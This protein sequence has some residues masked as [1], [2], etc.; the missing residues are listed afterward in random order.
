MKTQIIALIISFLNITPL[1]SQEYNVPFPE[2][3]NFEPLWVY[4]PSFSEQNRDDRDTVKDNRLYY[5]GNVKYNSQIFFLYTSLHFFGDEI[6]EFSADGFSLTSM[7]YHSGEV[8][9]KDIYNHPHG[10]DDYIVTYWNDN[11][12]FEKDTLTLIGNRKYDEIGLNDF[13]MAFER[14]YNINTG[15][16]YS[17][18]RDTSNHS[19]F[20]DKSGS[21][22]GIYLPLKDKSGYLMYH[23]EEF[24]WGDNPSL[25]MIFEIIN[26]DMDSVS[27]I[28]KRIYYEPSFEPSVWSYSR[29][30]PYAKL[31]DSII[32][33]L[34][35]H[36]NIDDNWYGSTTEMYWINVADVNNIHVERKKRLDDL[37]IFNAWEW[38]YMILKVIDGN[39]CI[40]DYFDDR[41]SAERSTYFLKMDAEGNVLNYKQHIMSGERN[42]LRIANILYT[43]D[44]V[45]YLEMWW[46]GE[47]DYCNAD[48]VAVYQ[49]GTA[50]KVASMDTD[51][52]VEGDYT[53]WYDQ[54]ASYITEDGILVEQ[55]RTIQKFDEWTQAATSYIFGV[56]VRDLGIPWQSNTITTNVPQKPKFIIYP[57]PTSSNILITS[58]KNFSATQIELYTI[59]GVLV[60]SI[61]V[62]NAMLNEMNIDLES[63]ESGMYILQM[64][65]G[66]RLLTQNKVTKL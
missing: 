36:R 48:I 2:Y 52:L 31:N 43:D 62:Q 56:N 50:E 28:I 13:P 54:G 16:L 40:T 57:N 47:E 30:Y 55:I 17:F 58:E 19:K 11:F 15:E 26:N 65:D 18:K 61:N 63:L 38:Q 7:D 25:Q 22:N 27:G 45:T 39:I 37:V 51:V 5:S 35:P 24:P 10:A 41:T 9:W 32:I 20:T 29:G 3:K 44:E 1:L 6:N 46:G 21:G 14:K 66:A 59:H 8:L 49:D 60:K 33:Q 42:Y 53:V 23:P 12:L 64:Y 4:R 34:I